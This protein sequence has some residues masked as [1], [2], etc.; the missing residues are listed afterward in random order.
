[1]YDEDLVLCRSP[2]LR[3]GIIKRGCGKQ[4]LLRVADPGLEPESPP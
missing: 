3:F 4:L 2:I 1:M